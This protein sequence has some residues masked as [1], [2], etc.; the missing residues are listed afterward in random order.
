MYDHIMSYYDVW[1]GWDEALAMQLPGQV[2]VR[3][4]GVNH[5]LHAWYASYMSPLLLASAVYGL[6]E[7]YYKKRLMHGRFAWS[8]TVLL[9]LACNCKHSYSSGLEEL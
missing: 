1:L 7:P 5:V 3:P 2:H 9:S 4:I 6:S 8:T